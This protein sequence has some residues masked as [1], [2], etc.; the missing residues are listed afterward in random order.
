MS[1][2][3]HISG[4][5]HAARSGLNVMIGTRKSRLLCLAASVVLVAVS[6]TA[7]AL[8]VD[9]DNSVD[10]ADAQTVVDIRFLNTQSG[11]GL[12]FLGNESNLIKTKDD[13]YVLIDTGD[14]SSEIRRRIKAELDKYQNNGTSGKVTIDYL[15]ISHLDKDHY[16]NAVSLINNDNITVKNV[17]VKREGTFAKYSSSKDT[18]YDNI[19]TATKKEKAN[20]YT[21]SVSHKVGGSEVQN[22]SKYH[23]MSE[24]GVGN[25]VLTVGSYLKLYFYNT[26]DV[27]VDKT[28]TKGYIFRFTAKTDGDYKYLKNSSG[29][30]FRLNTVGVTYPTGIKYESS[31]SMVKGGSGLESYYYAYLYTEDDGSY[32]QFYTCRSNPNSYGVL[33]EITTNVGNKYVYFPNDLDNYAYDLKPAKTNVTYYSSKSGKNVTLNNHNVYGNGAGK[34]YQSTKRD[35]FLNNKLVSNQNKIYSETK[36]AL[37]IKDKLGDNLSNLVI[38]EIAHHGSNNAKDAMDIL[39]INRP[40]MYAVNNRKTNLGGGGDIISRQTYYHALGNIKAE[41]KMWSGQNDNG[42]YLSLIHI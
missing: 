17:V 3:F 21:N 8:V 23:H 9:K 20:L 12:D 25:A 36:V 14:E 11:N 39:N 13:K 15:I 4:F 24:E 22:Y 16:G 34:V 38:Y 7:A 27:F 37:E 5:R 26:T 32:K 33:A 31:S 1:K 2:K 18:A 29:Q 40:N 10:A 28:C 35:D 41:N 19:V 30:Y 6:A 42:V